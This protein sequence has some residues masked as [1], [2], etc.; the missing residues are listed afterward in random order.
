V[1]C[2]RPANLED[3]LGVERVADHGQV[4]VFP[5]HQPQSSA[6][7]QDGLTSGAQEV[8][9]V[10]AGPDLVRFLLQSSLA[11]EELL[12]VRHP[13]THSNWT[14]QRYDCRSCTLPGRGKL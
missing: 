9:Q 11:T 10:E 6:A 5:D 4:E 7:D 14:K 1:A 8:V 13:F 12:H 3:T 2:K